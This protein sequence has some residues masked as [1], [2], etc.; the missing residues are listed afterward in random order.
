MPPI[1]VLLVD[2]NEFG[3]EGIGVLLG[4]AGIEVVGETG[5]G[6]DAVHLVSRLN[7]DVVVTD[8][9]HPGLDGF[10]LIDRIRRDAPH[11]RVVV[12]TATGDARWIT[13]GMELGADGFVIKCES[14]DAL[15]DVVEAVGGGR[16]MLSPEARRYWK[17]GRFGLGPVWR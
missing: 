5:D 7:P 1:R 12:H 6:D 14:P 9:R 17:A 13:H 10:E 11:V 3:R 15:V 16:R 8:V 4:L 2:D